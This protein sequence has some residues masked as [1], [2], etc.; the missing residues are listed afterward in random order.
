MYHS[1]TFSTGT[2][3]NGKLTGV[4][5][6][7]N[8]H[9][10]PTSRPAFA[11]P[12]VYT[13]FVEVPGQDGSVDLSNYL[14]ENAIFKDRKGSFEFYVT[15][16]IEEQYP[17]LRNDIASYLRSGILWASLEDDP[18][19]YYIGRFSLKQWRQDPHFSQITIDYQ[20]CPYKYSINNVGGPM[21][22]DTFNFETDYDYG[23]LLSNIS[24]SGTK[25]VQIP[26]SAN[27]LFAPT[28]TWLSG[29]VTASFGG[30]SK[31]VNS[32]NQ[33][34]ILGTSPL[35]TETTIVLSGTGSVSID[36]R[37]RML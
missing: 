36:Y 5:T 8:W 9:L 14:S 1:I 31:T 13:K 27:A 26:G 17:T 19:Y 18:G 32:S 2:I 3:S 25:N 34:A 16:R 21:I 35:G 11:I 28:V 20:V 24:V 23:V 37:E 33:T 29:S 10:I 12:D 7:D 6:W 4:N 15:N 30:V 22:W